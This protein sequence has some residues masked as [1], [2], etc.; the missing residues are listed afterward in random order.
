MALYPTLQPQSG[1][2]QQPEGSDPQQRQNYMQWSYDRAQRRSRQN[3]MGGT[4]AQSQMQGPQARPASVNMG[5]PVSSDGRITASPPPTQAQQQPPPQWQ[6][7][8]N[9][10]N[11]APAPGAQGQNAQPQSFFNSQNPFDQNQ[12]QQGP[13]SQADKDFW[14]WAAEQ[15]TG[16]KDFWGTLQEGTVQSGSPNNVWVRAPNGEWGT[17]DKAAYDAKRTKD[18]PPIPGEAQFNAGNLGNDP[19]AAYNPYQFDQRGMPTY[20]AAT[21]GTDTPGAYDQTQFQQWQGPNMGNVGNLSRGQV[22]Q[23][24]QNPGTMSNQNVAQLREMQKEQ[25]AQ[26]LRDR[27]A[28][29]SQQ[30]ASSGRLGSGYMNA[31]AQ[32]AAEQGQQ[33]LL[34]GA[35]ELNLQQ[36]RQNRQDTLQALDASNQWQQGEFG[37]A[38]QGFQNTLQGQALQAGENQFGQNDAWR[39]SAFDLGLQQA[40]ADEQKAAYQSQAGARAFDFGREQ[41][42]AGQNYQGYGS[43]LQAQELSLQRALQ[44]QGLNLQ[45]AQQYASNWA[46]QQGLQQQNLGRASQ[47][48]IAGED[49][50]IRR[51]AL[52]DQM[53]QF[54]KNYDL[55]QAQFLAGL[56][57]WNQ[58]FGEDQRQFNTNSAL[59]W[60]QFGLNNRNSLAGMFFPGGG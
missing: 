50:G 28:Q 42:Q 7:V 29:L 59:N 36:A 17:M 46:T 25:V 41:A 21:F 22:E 30:A 44:Q 35:R 51:Q 18:G 13:T 58:Q 43:Q 45:Q 37:R 57:Q 39:R 14:Q 20:D 27:Q 38:S 11:V 40:N 1:T 47:E 19:F 10:G 8:Q 53:A 55:N 31:Q 9:P 52:G 49:L 60:S 32:R 3:Q 34:G 6:Q 12:W 16:N 15:Q 4:A 24:L 2:P 48:R 54:N 56:G 5:T 23:M 26:S 33:Q